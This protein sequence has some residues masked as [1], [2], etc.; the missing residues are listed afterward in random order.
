MNRFLI[1][2]EALRNHDGHWYEYN[3]ATKS[4][5]LEYEPEMQIDM[6]GHQSMEPS[7]AKELSASPHFRFT[8]WDQIYN[9]PQAWK[10]YLGVLQHNRRLYV[11]LKRYLTTHAKYDFV[12]APTVVLHL[13][14]ILK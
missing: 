6:L 14:L 3:R 4:A 2:E 13:W 7:V 12:F 8:V 1:T 10:R 5:L 11:D 9:Q